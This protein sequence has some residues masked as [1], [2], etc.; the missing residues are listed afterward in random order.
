[1]TSPYI[2]HH[3]TLTNP[4]N[5]TG[6]RYQAALQIV[7]DIE[8]SSEN[9][10]L[11]A[12]DLKSYI[13]IIKEGKEST[14][15]QPVFDVLWKLVQLKGHKEDFTNGGL[16]EFC[17]QLVK[18]ERFRL[19]SSAMVFFLLEYSDMVT[20]M[21]DIGMV[22]V[23]IRYSDSLD[24]KALSSEPRFLL[25]TRKFVF[26]SLRLISKQ[27]SYWKLLLEKKLL[28]S[29][30]KNCFNL[31]F[32]SSYARQLPDSHL[33]EIRSDELN[34]LAAGMDILYNLSEQFQNFGKIYKKVRKEEVKYVY[35]YDT[36]D[37]MSQA[38]KGGDGKNPLQNFR[39]N[40]EMK[41]EQNLERQST[42]EI[43]GQLRALSLV[44]D[45][46]LAVMHTVPDL[47]L[48]GLRTLYM[49]SHVLHLFTTEELR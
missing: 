40:T 24:K 18:D 43:L 16:P 44:D 32:A 31:S 42:E 2:A 15:H 8:Q 28:E 11:A 30:K 13:G 14:L 41:H 47:S 23:L 25:K 48:L 26:Q 21:V 49:I 6:A 34:L 3:S 37:E 9:A 22:D 33:G 20:E 7:H 45:V 35:D 5:E 17:I 19:K 36:E 1:M 10:S 29:V 12:K 4:R 46:L 38:S 27:S 39:R